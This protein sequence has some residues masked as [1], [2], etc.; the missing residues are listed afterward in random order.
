[1]TT[2]AV[3]LT[4]LV[5]APALAASVSAVDFKFVPK[6]ITVSP[7]TTVTWTNNGQSPHT[8]TGSGFDSGNL[9]PGQTFSHTFSTSGTFNYHCQ[10]HQNLGMVGTVVVTGGGGSGGGSGTPL[11]NTGI[12]S[13]SLVAAVAGI[14]LLLLGAVLL[15]GLRRRRA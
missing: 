4:V 8:V 9:N 7:G 12:G 14:A 5:A 15:F 13:G 6:T 2:V 1:V 10:Y 3:G 11:P